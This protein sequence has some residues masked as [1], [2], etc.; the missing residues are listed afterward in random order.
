MKNKDKVKLQKAIDE[1]NSVRSRHF[2]RKS[3]VNTA[4]RRANHIL[5]GEK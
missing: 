3:S 1:N 2:S 5:K 4:N